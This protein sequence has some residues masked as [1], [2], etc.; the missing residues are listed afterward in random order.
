MKLDLSLLLVLATLFTGVI[1]AGYTIVSRGRQDRLQSSDGEA[2]AVPRLVE[3]SRSFFPVLLLVLAIRSFAFEP[4]RIPSSSMVPTLLVGDFIFVAKYSYGL[5]LPVLHTMVLET[6]QPERGDIAV[7]RLPTDPSINY[8][9]RVV[10]LP[11]D[12]ILYRNHRLFING[13]PVQLTP[14]EP[15]E[16]DGETGQLFIEQLGDSE[17]LILLQRSPLAGV[18]RFEVPAGCY[19]M[20]G[21]NR[22][23]SRDSRFPQVGCVPEDNLV[24]RA[25]RIWLNWRWGEWPRWTRIGDK[26]L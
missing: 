11:G 16:E 19:F 3:Y 20:M 10:G 24:G 2:R 17:H 14:A 21:D 18:Y 13:E 4:Y 23:N 22:D 25:S 26:I 8:I 1:W 7:F 5:R 9:K 15:Y 6:G 12:E